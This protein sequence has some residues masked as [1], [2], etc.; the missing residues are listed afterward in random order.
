[1]TDAERIKRLD[2]VIDQ[3]T[4]VGVYPRSVTKGGITTERTEWQDGWNAAITEVLRVYEN[5]LKEATKL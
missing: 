5:A 4:D 2:Y 1:M 3:I